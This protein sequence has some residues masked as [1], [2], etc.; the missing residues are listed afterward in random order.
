MR[1][2][3]L[4]A[5]TVSGLGIAVAWVNVDAGWA[6]PVAGACALGAGF[7]GYLFI[8]GRGE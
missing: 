8:A 1:K 2:L 5:T 6:L 4:I 7:F 3:Y